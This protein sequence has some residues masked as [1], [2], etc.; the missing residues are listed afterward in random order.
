M[1]DFSPPGCFLQTGHAAAPPLPAV[2]AGAAPP[3]PVPSLSV[4]EGVTARALRPPRTAAASSADVVTSAD[5]SSAPTA[6]CAATLPP[7][8]AVMTTAVVAT[9]PML[10]DAA[11]LN[12]CVL[13]GAPTVG[14]A[15]GGPSPPFAG[16]ALPPFPAPDAARPSPHDSTPARAAATKPVDGAEADR[17]TPPELTGA[18]WPRLWRQLA[19]PPPPRVPL[20][21]ALTAPAGRP[22]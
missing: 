1:G 5:A 16:P 19:T 21:A 3:F 8:Q 18:P 6:L 9:A 20:H 2:A 10:P 12:V 4:W 15:S 14:R 13:C 11:F 7:R 22:L 17:P